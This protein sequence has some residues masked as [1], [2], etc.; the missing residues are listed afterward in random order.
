MFFVTF[1]QDLL[2]RLDNKRQNK[3]TVAA[4]QVLY[5]CKT[6]NLQEPVLSGSIVQ[7]SIFKCRWRKV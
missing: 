6:N 3:T 4:G 2:K 7:Y 1:R 5:F